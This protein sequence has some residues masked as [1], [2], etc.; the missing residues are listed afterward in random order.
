MQLCPG[1]AIWADVSVF[2]QAYR[3]GRGVQGAYLEDGLAE[4]MEEA[5]E[6]YGEGLLPNRYENWCLEERERFGHKYLAMRDQ[7]MDY[8]LSRT[9]LEEAV[10][11]GRQILLC[12]N[13]HE[14]THRRLM[15][16]HHLR[17]DRTSALRQYDLCT[18]ALKEELDVDPSEATS[19]L[20]EKIR[21]EKVP[22]SIDKRASAMVAQSATDSLREFQVHLS[23]LQ[24]SLADMERRLKSLLLELKT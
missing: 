12:D 21:D 17:N 18:A 5:V 7:L 4:A 10:E 6:L 9:R 24:S 13:S 19:E 1:Q 16:L 2:E 3:E 15:W 20:Y 14:R 11:Q 22:T 8:H 23:G